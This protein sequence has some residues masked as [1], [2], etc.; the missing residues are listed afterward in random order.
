MYKIEFS[1]DTTLEGLLE[2]FKNLKDCGNSI[3]RNS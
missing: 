1:N 2:S 3:Q